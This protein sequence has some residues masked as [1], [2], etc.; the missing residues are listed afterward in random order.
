MELARTYAALIDQDEGMLH[1][2][3]RAFHKALG[4]LGLTP[5]ARAALPQSE[6][7]PATPSP[8]EELR[9]RHERRLALYAT[10]E[11]PGR[12]RQQPPE[13]SRGGEC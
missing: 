4:E 1:V 3:G 8:L 7:R 9:A 11:A 5:R 6:T 10:P 12:D 13:A 2:V